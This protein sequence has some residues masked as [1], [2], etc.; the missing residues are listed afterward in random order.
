MK[1]IISTFLTVFVLLGLSSL[2]FSQDSRY[3]DPGIWN[4]FQRDNW[5]KQRNLPNPYND[6]PKQVDPL[7]YGTHPGLPADPQPNFVNPPDIRVFPSSNAQSENSIAVNTVTPTQLFIS[8][9][10]MIPIS[11]SVVQ[12]TWFFSTNG[13]LNWFGSENVPPPILDCIGDPVAIFDLFNRAFY[14]T[15]GAVGTNGSGIYVVSTVDFGTTWSPR[16]QAD[17]NASSSNDKEHAM[18]DLSGIFPN[19]VYCA[20][21]DYSGN[22]LIFTRSTTNGT[23]WSS[24]QSYGTGVREQGCNIA[25]GPNGE[26]Y[27]AVAHYPSQAETGIDFIKSTDGGATFSAM[28][29]AFPISGIRITNSGDSRFNGVRVNSFPHMDVDRSTGSRRGNIYIVDADQSTGNAEIKMWTSTNTGSTWSGPTQV[30]T[31]SSSHKWF[32]SVAVDKFTGNIA[33]SYYNFDSVGFYA[34]RNLAISSDGGLTWDKGINSDEHWLYTYQTTPNTAAGYNG[35]YFETAIL[36]NK[37]YPCWSEKLT[38][39]TYNQAKIDIITLGPPPP[40]QAHDIMTGPFMNLPSQFLINTAYNIKTRVQN[41]GTNNE[42]NVPI[43]WFINGTQTSSTNKNLNAGQVDS[44]SNTWTPTVTGTYSL[45]YVSALGTDTNRINDTVRTSVVVLTQIPAMCVFTCTGPNNTYTPITGTAGPSGDDATLTVP[46]G[47]TFSYKSTAFTQA[48]ICTNGWVALGSTTSTTYSNDLASTT[49]INLIAGFWD[50][51][52]PPSG[53]NIQYTT[54]GSAPNRIFI[55][56]WTNVAFISGPGNAT[57]Q[58]RLY[59]NS[60]PAND[61]SIEIKYGPH[62]DDPSRTGSIGI[63]VAPGSSGNFTSITPGSSGCSNTTSSTTTSNN[64]LPYTNL[65]SGTDYVFCPP[66]VGISHNDNTVPTVYSL[67]QNYPNPFN[68]TTNIQFALPKAS[69]VKLVVYDLLGAEVKTLVNEHMQAGTHDVS[70][71]GTNLA[72]GVYF[73]KIQ[74]GDFTAVKKMLMVK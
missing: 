32:P 72:S 8:T 26:V 17:P 23:T 66:L 60:N 61:G 19:N 49:D 39:Y 59:E 58:I 64:S 45:M 4:M 18:A 53:G 31:L 68:P 41:V 25:I 47:F 74:A 22:N 43:R 9:N 3:K 62:T 38:S 30:S 56:Q 55:C 10:G 6:V 73:Y 15:M 70:F 2:T 57:F 29:T 37:V 20:W 28:V 14:V 65:P 35:D 63:N 51:L 1:R 54:Q 48:S 27:I 69:D 12:Q 71:N 33:V 36:N 24:R 50:D 46:L 67:S 16:Y 7:V 11:P 5:Y 40:P 13:G 21:W 52:Y 34:S 44:V 42:T